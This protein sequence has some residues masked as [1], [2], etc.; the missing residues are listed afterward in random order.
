MWTAEQKNAIEKEGNLIVSAAAGAGKT[1]VMTERIVRIIREGTKVDE[2]LVVTFTKPAAAE[3]KQRIEKRLGELAGEAETAEEKLLLSDAAA[4]I[5]RANISTIHSFCKNVLKRNY[6]KIG[7]DP[8]FRV[9]DDAEAQLLV[10]EAQDSA[11]EEFY[12]NAEKNGDEASKFLIKALHKDGGLASTVLSI[13]RFI[14]ARPEPLKWLENVVERYRNGFESAKEAAVRYLIELSKRDIDVFFNEANELYEELLETVDPR[15]TAVLFDDMQHLLGV[16]QLLSYDRWQ[17][18]LEDYTFTKI[19]SLK[20]KMPQK[21]ELF[22]KKEKAMIEKLHERFIF[23]LEEEKKLALLLYPPLEK[24]CSIVRSFMEKY[25]FLKQKDA[26]IDFSDMEQLT[27]AALGDDETAEEYRQKFRYIFVDEYQDTNLVQDKIIERVSRGN[28]LFMVGDIKQSIYRFR[29]AEPANFIEKYNRYDGKEGTRI[30]LNHNFRSATAV[31]N[32]TNALFSKL[33]LGN[34]GEIDYS[35]NAALQPGEGENAASGSTELTL[36]ELTP[37]LY[38][39][40]VSDGDEA[41]EAEAEAGKENGGEEGDTNKVIEEIESIEAEGI[42]VSKKIAELLETAEVYDKDSK[43]MR[44]PR[45]SDFAILLRRTKGP[46]LR[47]INTLTERGIPCTAELG[48]GYFEALEVQVFMNL[49]RIIDNARQDIPLVSVM[50]SPIGGFTSAELADI[51]LYKKKVPFIESLRAAAEKAEKRADECSNKAKHFLGN[52]LRWRRLSRLVGIEELIGRLFDET[53]YYIYSGALQ[54]GPVRQANLDLLLEKAHSFEQSGGRGLHSFIT[55]MDSVRDNT[56]LGAAQAASVDAVRVMSIHKSKGL[57]FPIVFICGLSGGFS[58]MDKKSTAVLDNELGLGLR[59]TKGYEVLSGM[60]GVDYESAKKALFRRA[61]EAKEASKQASEEM[62]ILYVAMTRARE[63]LY[64]VAAAKKMAKLVE[65]CAAP[66]NDYRIINANNCLDWLLGAYF[67]LGLN[68]QNCSKGVKINLNGDEL[69]CFYRAS[70]VG[71]SADGRV[72]KARFEAWLSE[73]AAAP[74]KELDE[75]LSFDY[76]F[77]SDVL[78]PAKSSV[79]VLSAEKYEYEPAVPSFMQQESEKRITGAQRGTLTHRFIMLLPL[80][81]LSREELS[82]QLALLTKRGLF[83]EREAAAV[84]LNAVFDLVSSQLYKRMLAAPLV[85]REQE[86]TTLGE[87]GVLEQGIID[88]FFV[89]N[90]KIVLVDY[91]TT[92]VREKGAEEVAASYKL[93]LDLYKKALE[94]LTD[95]PVKEEWIYLLSVPGAYRIG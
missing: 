93:Q 40:T 2:L 89:E 90:G 70:E 45:Y 59:I 4:D 8:S 74:H 56:N 27:L 49:L 43:S 7:I 87:N 3:M 28:N 72:D 17:M 12:E 9:A 71:E 50:L 36:I 65:N 54:S 69:A 22:R 46:A 91:K 76:A 16:S 48:D 20:G 6:H 10:R 73:A 23:P 63:R 39:R 15:Y 51:R 1:A 60:E 24:L 61:I 18:A 44:K 58:T 35:D 26:L 5:S 84:K 31:L 13:Y 29:Q 34:V 68:L 11:I 94:A 30:D 52:I 85:K 38:K 67:P 77:A 78:T 32:T 82:E 64:M 86:F 37:E 66:L 47:L 33:M 88:C 95:L 42:Y 57:E 25:A 62:R 83:S 53:K 75:R 41:E 55:L 79:T 80:R 21:L 92:S 81:P 19:P 14:I